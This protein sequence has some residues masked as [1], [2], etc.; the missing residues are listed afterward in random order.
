[1]TTDRPSIQAVLYSKEKERFLIIGKKDALSDTLAWRLVKGGVKEDETNIVALKREIYEEVGLKEVKIL[2]RVNYYE[3][4]YMNQ[5]H[6]VSVYLVEANIEEK[7]TLQGESADE[8]PIIDYAWL[9]LD[10]VLEK[11]SWENE[12]DSLK[13]SLKYI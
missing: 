8:T 9:T 7:V 6:Q 2:D 13:A 10:E 1:M 12:R 3:F 5:N 4:H 11:L